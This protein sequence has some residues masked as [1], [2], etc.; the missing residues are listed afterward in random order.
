MKRVLFTAATDFELQSAKDAYNELVSAS[1]SKTENL[2]VDFLVTGITIIPTLHKLTLAL[3]E[4]SYDLAVNLGIAG[5]YKEKKY[6]G[7]LCRI[8]EEEFDDIEPKFNMGPIKTVALDDE[9]EDILS[10]YPQL[11]SLTVSLAHKPV[12]DG[13]EVE[14]MEGA[15]FFYVCR[16]MCQPYVE[17]RAIS[18]MVGDKDKRNWKIDECLEVLRKA[19][20]ELI[21][22]Y[23]R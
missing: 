15:A 14:N 7:Q 23:A 18:N 12:R 8:L 10:R 4:Q 9:L 5:A 2:Q 13:K 3:K 11:D 22:F 17:L 21:K 16:E 6:L 19:S 1:T 20:E